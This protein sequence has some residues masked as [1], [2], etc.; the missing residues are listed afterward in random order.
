MVLWVRF[1][2]Y[3]REWVWSTVGGSADC[4]RFHSA[5]LKQWLVP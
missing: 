4:R 3:E 2:E 1:L 5:A